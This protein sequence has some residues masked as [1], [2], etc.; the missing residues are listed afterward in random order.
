V[1]FDHRDE[2]QSA[3]VII[4]SILRQTVAALPVIPNPV[5]DMYQKL[6]ASG[7][8]L[9]LDKLTE[10]FISVTSSL[11]RLFVV[12][13]ALDECDNQHRSMVLQLLRQLEDIPN[14]RIFVTSRPYPQDIR[15]ALSS[16]PQIEIKA[17]DSDLRQYML[18][19]VRCIC[20]S[21]II[22]FQFAYSMIS[23]LIEASKGV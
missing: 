9:T 19:E 17:H 8:H 22:D 12:I 10:T 6:K 4:A 11:S 1:Y 15:T 20:E 14:V 7:H 2:Q 16:S 21:G 18:Q 13:D 5:R 3:H 23:R